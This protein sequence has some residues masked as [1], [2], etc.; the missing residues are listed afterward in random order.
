MIEKFTILTIFPEIIESYISKSIPKQAQLKGLVEIKVINI[1]SHPQ[2]Q[3]DDYAYGGGGMVLKV[4]PIVRA[5][6]E[7]NLL[8]EHIIL[9][10]PAGKRL[11]QEKAVALT[12]TA[13]H[14]VLICGHYEGIDARINKYIKEEISIGDYVLSSG[15]LASL[16]LLDSVIRLIPNVINKDSLV[17]ESFNDYLLDYPVYTRPQNFEGDLVPDIYLSGDHKAIEKYRLKIREKITEEKRPD[18]FRKYLKLK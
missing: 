11:N 2:E 13:K 5:L 1:R 7:H 4:E 17:C 15:E 18:L 12:T 10:T 3:V 6:R 8:N 16:V 9:L 14:I